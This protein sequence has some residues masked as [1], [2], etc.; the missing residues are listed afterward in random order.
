MKY[1]GKMS[2]Y[3]GKDRKEFALRDRAQA[4]SGLHT[5][6]RQRRDLTLEIAEV[7]EDRRAR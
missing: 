6:L 4:K 2:M 1:R 5:A 7:I 3:V